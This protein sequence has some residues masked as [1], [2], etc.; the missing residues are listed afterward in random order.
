M[1]GIFARLP[2]DQCAGEQHT[3]TSV[4][5]GNYSINLDS[6]IN[7]TFKNN[8]DIPCV[9]NEKD[10]GCKSCTSNTNVLMGLGPE[11]FGQKADIEDNLKGIKRNLTKCASEKFLSCD[12]RVPNRIANECNNITVVTPGICERHIVP[13]NMVRLDKGF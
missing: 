2:Y 7:P 3:R 4:E 10:I 12:F 8:T 5:P 1:S 13:T 9:N 6:H 11:N